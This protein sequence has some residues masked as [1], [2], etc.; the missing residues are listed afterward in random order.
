MTG[1]RRSGTLGATLSSRRRRAFVGRVSETELFEAALDAEEAPPFSVLYLHGPGGVGKS[2]LLDVFAGLAESRGRTVVR[3]DGHAVPPTRAAVLETWPAAD[4]EGGG[5]LVVLIDAYERLAP[6][7]G[8]IRTT[9]LPRLPVSA[10]TVMAGRAPPSDAWRADPAWR[11]LLRIVSLRNLTPA[12]SRAYLRAS[13]VDASRHGTLVDATHGHPLAL[14]LVTD[15]V[16]RGGDAPDD[17]L[18][19][20]LVATLVHRFVDAVPSAHHRR[21]LEVCALARVTTEALLRHALDVDDAHDLFAW[22]RELSFVETGPHG[23]VPHDLARDVLDVDLRW[24]DPE[25]YAEVFRSVRRHIH[26]RLERVSGADQQ[27]AI[28]DE[29]FVFR[30][31]PSVLSPVEWRDWGEHYP[32]PARH[33]DRRAI[34]DMIGTAEGPESASIAAEWWRRQP[35]AF[36]VLRDEQGDVRGVLGLVTLTGGP[37]AFGFDPGAVAA[38]TYAERT[39]PARPGEVVTQ[40]RFVVDSDR[41]QAPSPTLNATPIVTIQR[42]LQTPNLAWDFLTL[43]DPDALNEYFAIADLPRASGADFLVGERTYGLFAH[44]FRAVPV[45]PWL[46]LVTDRALAQDPSL[47]APGPDLLVL[48]Q[49]AF[50]DAARQALRD[51][52]RPDLLARNPLARTRLVAAETPSGEEGGA[53]LARLVGEAVDSLRAHPRDDKRWRALDRTYLRPAPTQEKA[54][55]VLGLPFSTY[56]RHL[57]EGVDRVVSHLWDWEVYAAP[58]RR[59]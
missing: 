24:R 39:A 32:E 8:W 16:L 52:S 44:D 19:P 36:H 34:V 59:D 43:A 30:N 28:Y 27:R 4:P 29:K 23:L 14:S 55:E 21:A 11:D 35:Q 3:I 53:V 9:L 45:G 33:E 51:L 54:A 26:R 31:L 10:I 37:G 42:Y 47:P 49:P 46:E 1:T 15:V 6:L 40:T 12:E 20:D 22:L 17:P 57:S 56:R 13:D 7:D 41:Y 25:A 2:T 38:W 58:P 50:A 18:T 48:S 5:P